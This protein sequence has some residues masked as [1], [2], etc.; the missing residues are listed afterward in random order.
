[1]GVLGNSGEAG[2]TLVRV[3]DL[4]FDRCATGVALDSDFTLWVS[5][6]N[7]LNRVGLDGRLIERIPVEPKG[8]VV[9][10]RTFA[11]L[12]DTLYFLGNLPDGQF[13]L[14]AAPMTPT[15]VPKVARPILRSLP[16]RRRD[17]IPYCLAPQ[18]LN[19]RLVLACEPKEFPDRIGIYVEN[20]GHFWRN[21]QARRRSLA[22]A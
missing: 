8:S 21:R 2:A 4:P 16:E 6:G 7:T 3:G 13:V 17:Y 20:L 5:G 11:V 9:N 15:K 12:N 1:M 10:S 19:G 14:F 18:P 22:F